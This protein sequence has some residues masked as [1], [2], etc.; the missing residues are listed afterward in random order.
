[1][2]DAE[3]SV[4]HRSDGSGT[5]FVWSDY[6]S[7]VSSEW[8]ASVG[9]G[10]TVEWP[11]GVGAERNEGVASTVEQTP[12]SLGYVEFIYAI[13]HELSFGAVR[14]RAGQFI[15][16]DISSVT[17]AARASESPD[18]EFR[19][20]IT[21]SPGKSAYPIATHTWLLLSDP[22]GDKDKRTVLVELLRWALTSGQKS[23]SA[24][25]YAPLPADIAKRALQSVDGIK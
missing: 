13:Q 15:K 6:L 12:N 10:V 14:N 7:K 23:C 2:P 4:I 9:S 20:S 3:I 18:A 24:L 21:S 22:V 8:K 17:A 19:V 5:T 25:G 11:V 1:M 16:A